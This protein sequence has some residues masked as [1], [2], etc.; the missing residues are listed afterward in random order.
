MEYRL[1]QDATQ[2]VKLFYTQNV[3]D[4]LDGYT[5]EYGGGFIWRRKLDNFW[6]IFR[7]WKKEQPLMLRP[8]QP[9]KPVL[10]DT[11]QTDSL[12]NNPQ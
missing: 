5:S 2:Y 12:I 9:Q 11:I 7:F 1:N 10:R 8:M 3:Y 6:D 4:W